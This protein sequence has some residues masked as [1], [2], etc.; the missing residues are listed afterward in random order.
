MSVFVGS[1]F[2]VSVAVGIG[3]SERVVS[4]A[5]GLV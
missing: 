1:V 4:V 5:A 3:V 2:V